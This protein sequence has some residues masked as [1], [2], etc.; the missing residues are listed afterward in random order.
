MP[1]KLQRGK[2]QILLNYLPGR[3]FDFDRVIYRVDHIRGTPN[4][5]LNRR[6]ILSALAEYASAWKEKHRPTLGD[7]AF[8]R[9]DRFILLD[10]IDVRATLFP[11][12]FWCQGAGCGRV[13]SLPDGKVPH[14]KCPTCNRGRLVQLRFVRVHRC[15]SLQPLRPYYCRK[16]KTSSHITLNT[17]GSERIGNFR[18][19]CRKCGKTYSVFG[20][21]CAEC[22]WTIP[23]PG[24]NQPKHTGIEVHRAGRTFYPHYVVLL[25]QPGQQLNSF[26]AMSN[27][28]QLSSAA[29]L[30]LPEMAGRRLTDLRVD[31]DRRPVPAQFDEATLKAQG[32]TEEQVSQFLEMQASLASAQQQEEPSSPVKLAQA[33]VERTGVP[34]PV[35]RRA[36]QEMLEAVLPLQSSTK[37]QIL[38]TNAGTDS[39]FSARSMGV[40]R[41]TLVVDFPVTRATFG[42]SRVDDKPDRCQLNPFPPAR[43]HNGRHPIFVDVVQADALIVRLNPLRVWRWLERNGKSS[44]TS[45]GCQ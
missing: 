9:P 2:Q 8:T 43:D 24:V 32:F 20:G 42:F 26:L 4:T 7:K 37:K 28:Q 39:S 10:P 22:E 25:N 33:L 23:V 45:A 15:G 11:S 34:A 6:L 5:K 17:H 29:F 14:S 13:L 1:S 36:G 40:E 27:W 3:T 44:N 30:E 35:W 19:Q 31:L 21:P 12:V 16:C 38:A 41:I 18:W